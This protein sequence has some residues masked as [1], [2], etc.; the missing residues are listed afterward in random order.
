MPPRKQPDW[1]NIVVALLLTLAGAAGARVMFAADGV[2]VLTTRAEQRD[3]EVN[4]MKADI[5][6][7][8]AAV[9]TLAARCK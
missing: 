9:A 5:R 2:N 7:L 1:S 3:T 4:D 8:R 6:E